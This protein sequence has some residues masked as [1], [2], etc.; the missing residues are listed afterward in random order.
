MRVLLNVEFGFVAQGLKE[1]KK[2]K[3]L[4]KGTKTPEMTIILTSEMTFCKF[5][6]IKGSID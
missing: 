4:N 5:K 1:V 2:N 6:Q 3:D